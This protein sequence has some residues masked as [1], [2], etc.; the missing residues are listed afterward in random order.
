MT[1]EHGNE[2]VPFEV[3]ERAETTE[4]LVA[5]ANTTAGEPLCPK[6]SCIRA[7]R[8][9]GAIFAARITHT[10]DGSVLGVTWQHSLGDMNTI[11][12]LMR[13]WSMACQGLPHDVPLDVADRELYLAEHLVDSPGVTSGLRLMPLSFL[14]YT[15]QAMRGQPRFNLAFS[16]EDM[17]AIKAE[18]APGRAASVDDALWARVFAAIR[19]IRKQTEPSLLV[20]AINLRKRL[21]LPDNLLGNMLAGVPVSVAEGDDASLIAARLRSGIQNFAS[22]EVNYH[23][24]MKWVAEHFSVLERWRHFPVIIDPS[25]GYLMVS[26]VQNFGL[27]DLIFGSHPPVLFWATSGETP[28]WWGLA[29]ESPG[30]VREKPGRVLSLWLPPKLGAQLTSEE[31]RALW[32]APRK[33]VAPTAAAPTLSWTTT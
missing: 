4:A 11:M 10:L 18:V 5:Q 30:V 31:G 13:A 29:F 33:Q 20:M 7:L 27:Y 6:L 25:L 32:R 23:A 21:D 16:W 15:A 19:S 3:H 8:G 9:K 2:G 17:Q 26:T 22:R 24:T 14:R 12:L 28:M 1:I